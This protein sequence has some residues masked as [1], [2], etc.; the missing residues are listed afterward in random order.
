MRNTAGKSPGPKRKPDKPN[1]DQE[2]YRRFVEAAREL[3]TDESGRAFHDLMKAIRRR[4]RD[5]EDS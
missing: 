5:V 1:Q 2:Q 3:E 4:R